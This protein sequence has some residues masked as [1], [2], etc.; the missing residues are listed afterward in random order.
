M[1]ACIFA[2][3]C[4][5]EVIALLVFGHVAVIKFLYCVYIYTSKARGSRGNVNS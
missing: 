3:I 1:Y 2:K 4:L 5:S